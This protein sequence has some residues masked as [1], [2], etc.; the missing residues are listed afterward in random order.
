M[1]CITE[2]S[3]VTFGQS[4]AVFQS[5]TWGWEE[6][7]DGEIKFTPTA[8]RRYATLRRNNMLQYCTASYHVT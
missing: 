6:A 5:H 3:L 8:Y 4:S 7:A 1:D 2:I